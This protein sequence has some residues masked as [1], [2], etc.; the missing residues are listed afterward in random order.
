MEESWPDECKDL[1]KKSIN[2]LIGLMMIEE[3]SLWQVKSVL[4]EGEVKYMDWSVRTTTEYAHGE[5]TDVY[6]ETRLD[7][8]YRSMRPIHDICMHTEL[9]RLAM[10][11]HALRSLGVPRQ[12]ICTFKTDS[13]GFYARK[14]RKA[15]C[16][17]LQDLSFADLKRPKLLSQSEVSSTLSTSKVF[18]VEE[19]QEPLK[20][21][22][23]LPIIDAD[24]P[25][26]EP[27][28][29][30]EYPEEA[31][32]ELALQGRSFSLT[33]HAGSGKTFLTRKI[34]LALI[35]KGERVQC[36]GKTH[37]ACSLLD[38]PETPSMTVNRFVYK[39]ILSGSY[40]G[41]IVL[42]EMS[43]CELS[44]WGFLYR[45]IDTCNFICVGSWDQL[46]PVG[47]HQW[48]DTQIGD[49]CVERSRMFHSLC[50]GNRVTLKTCR[51]SD[52]TLY[53]WY[54]SLCPGG[55]R[56]E[57]DFQEVLEEAREFFSGTDT[58]RW[59]LCIDHALRRK[60]NREANLREKTKEAIWVK[61][62]K[63]RCANA[64]QDFWIFPQQT[65]MAHVQVSKVVK[66]GMF[67]QVKAVMDD[68]V[69]FEGGI[70]LPLKFVARNM[71][72]VHALTIQSSQGRT[73]P[74]PVEIISSHKRFTRKHL[75]ICLS[76]A[77]LASLV[78]V[79]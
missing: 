43:L 69:E 14:K 54:V 5:V 1:A 4:H 36:M 20:S 37:V 15:K 26:L 78:Q 51:R 30:T 74:G 41:W 68:T 56:Y 48:L 39:H 7:S 64:P 18:R 23:T 6:Y 53:D 19:K 24:P 35:E 27:F 66:N 57:T 22:P 59:T 79:R 58:P 71:R 60:I 52:S 31:A 50:G 46:P 61:V 76:R 45:L 65:L 63:T 10:A 38:S 28:E 47:G 2:S 73:L 34:C 77:T 9:T 75:M 8:G 49:D 67:Y 17:D 72:L 13:V 33:G 70:K 29:W 32:L 44:L 40:K 16:L 25:V 12:D 3:A 62:P 21:K 42:D 55:S 11:V